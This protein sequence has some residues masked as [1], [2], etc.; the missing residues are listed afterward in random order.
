MVSE[1][2]NL[3]GKRFGKLVVTECTQQTQN[4]YRVWRCRCDCGGEILVN[5]KRLKSGTVRDCG[6]VPRTTAQRGNVAEDLSGRTF[7]YLTV[8]RRAE[9]KGGRTCWLCRCDCGK[10][11]AV[12]ARDLKAGKVKSCGCHAHDHRHNRVDLTGQRFGRLTAIEPTAR[13]DKKG[14]VYWRCRCDCGNETEVTEDALVHG[15]CSS[16]GCLK[17]E[18]QKKI[19]DKLH[20]IDGTCV[21][22]LEKRKAR[23]DNTSGFRGVFKLKGGKYR[24]DIGFKGKRYYLGS[25][26]DYGEAVAARLEAEQM[27]QRG[28]LDAYYEW[29]AKADR[30]PGWGETHPL[31]F[32]VEKKDGGLVI[33]RQST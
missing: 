5:T 2:K 14:A 7:G 33:N 20:R 9:N 32:E 28:F 15:N 21:E 13:R 17:R 23:R 12:L 24:A 8:L 16:C 18:N 25:F 19:A 27:I 31:V 4:R 1:K 10:E 26:S 30:E 22:I 6:C 3:V 11:K 29:K